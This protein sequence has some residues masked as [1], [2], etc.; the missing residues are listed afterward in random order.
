MHELRNESPIGST[1]MACFAEADKQSV[2]TVAILAE[3]LAQSILLRD[4][5]K[6]V[7]LQTSQS[8]FQQL[9]LV[10]EAHYKEQ[11]HIVDVLID[12]I[13]MLGGNGRVLAS[14]FLKSTQPSCGPRVRGGPEQWVADLLDAHEL[15][16]NTAQPTAST[17]NHQWVREF[18]V[19]L[20]VLINDQQRMS[21]S[22][23]R[24]SRTNQNRALRL[25]QTEE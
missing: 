22:E 21:L 25:A 14:D 24:L 19:G 17:S 18:A 12:R 9:H 6:N 13:R 5:Y 16:L 2:E 20:V 7:R 8:Q 15:V 1:E 3:L 23:Q 11:L 4:L 10:F